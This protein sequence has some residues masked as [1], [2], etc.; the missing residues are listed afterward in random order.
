V[1]TIKGYASFASDVQEVTC[2][3]N[4]KSASATFTVKTK[5]TVTALP[6]AA[7]VVSLG[8]GT[9]VKQITGFIDSVE[10]TR[11]DGI[12]TV[13]GRDTLRRAVDYFLAPQEDGSPEYKTV[14]DDAGV[15]VE[16]L[17]TIAGLTVSPTT[18]GY[19]LFPNYPFSCLS[20]WDAAGEIIRLPLWR[21]YADPDG[22]IHLTADSLSV[23]SPTSHTIVMTSEIVLD[24]LVTTCDETINRMIV[25][26]ASNS[27]RSEKVDGASPL[28]WTKT[29]L[30]SSGIIPDQAT[31]EDIAT[32]NLNAYKSLV[33]TAN[34]KMVGGED[35][36][37]GEGVTISGGNCEGDWLVYET[38]KTV[39]KDGLLTNLTLRRTV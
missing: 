16:N 19:T 1:N 25:I 22:I 33:Q 27:I 29:G 6:G 26:G 12:T 3:H 10:V 9:L 21:I 13:N 36:F 18:I 14:A 37:A 39:S 17:L 23:P 4:M 30:I 11:R 7:A 5:Q 35:I 2:T 8:I 31:A 15:N 34:V 28:D 38:K 32:Y 24:N 20:V